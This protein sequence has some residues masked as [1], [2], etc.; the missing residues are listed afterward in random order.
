[1][2]KIRTIYVTDAKTGASTDIP[3]IVSA[4]Y[5]Y[6]YSYVMDGSDGDYGPTMCEVSGMTMDGIITTDDYTVAAQLSELGTAAGYLSAAS[7]GA[8]TRKHAFDNILFGNIQEMNFPD[9]SVDGPTGRYGVPF[10]GV[11]AGA[12]TLPSDHLTISTI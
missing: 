10:F 8:L 3:G 11:F 4:E 1:M 2:A 6:T 9:K 5:G 7:E 12:D